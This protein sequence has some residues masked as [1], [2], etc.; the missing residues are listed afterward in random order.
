MMNGSRVTVPVEFGGS[1]SQQS[2]VRCHAAALAVGLAESGGSMELT[3]PRLICPI[4]Q[5]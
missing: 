5:G 3:K 2:Y 4:G 1:K